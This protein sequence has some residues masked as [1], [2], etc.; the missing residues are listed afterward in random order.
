MLS[1]Y[2]KYWILIVDFV[3]ISLKGQKVGKGNVCLLFTWPVVA[4]DCQQMVV[5]STLHSLNK[6]R[7]FSPCPLFIFPL[8]NTQLQIIWRC[9]RDK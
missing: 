2:G 5:L 9:F 6:K 4:T 3:Q 8:G 1:Q 7:I